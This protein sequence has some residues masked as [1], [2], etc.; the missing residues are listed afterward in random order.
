MTESFIEEQKQIT[1]W[2][3]G[4]RFKKQVFGGVNEQD[5]WK[6]LEELNGMY[7]TVLIAERARY[8]ALIDHFKETG[9]EQDTREMTGDE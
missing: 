6:K 5:V 7:E 9:T 4:L 8:D 1:K 3:E 2:L